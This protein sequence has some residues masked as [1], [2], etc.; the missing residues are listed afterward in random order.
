ME[1]SVSTLQ[2]AERRHEV[3]GTFAKTVLSYV[4]R[5]MG[6]EAVTAVFWRAGWDADG[7]GLAESASW[8][9]HEMTVA[10]A[11]AAAEVC[12]DADI[13]RRA[14]EE[15]M[16]IA[17]ERD[18]IDFVRAAG[19]VPA[20]LELVAN[21]STQMSQGRTHEVI[22]VGE[23]HA[24]VACTY[25]RPEDAHAFY[26]GYAAG[27]FGLIPGVFGFEGVVTEPECMRRGADTCVIRLRW[28]ASSHQAPGVATAD[29]EESRERVDS[30]VTRFEELHHMA[31]ELAG[32]E[33]VDTLLA[34]ITDR[35]RV[36][37]GA[38]RNLLAVRTADGGR[39]HVHHRGF[40]NDRETDRITR[41]LLDG[42]LDEG[43]HTLVEAVSADGHVYG[44]LV[45]MY[46]RGST[47]TDMEHRLLGA[48]ARH[49]AAALEAVAALEG[50]R[51]D[52][53]VAQGLLGLAD[54]LA[55]ADSRTDVAERLAAAI[56]TVVERTHAQVWLWDPNAGCLRL[57]E[58]YPLGEDRRSR[59]LAASEVPEVARLVA[60]PAPAL[61]ERDAFPE[62][63]AD[64]VPADGPSRWALVPIQARGR[65]FGAVTVGAPSFAELTR[66]SAQGGELLARLRGMADQAATALDNAEL[67]EHIRAQALVDALT[68]LPN[69][70]LLEDRTR[71]AL[72]QA[73]RAGHGVTLVFIDLDDFKKVNDTLGHHAGDEVITAAA[74]RLHGCLRAS[75]TLA[76]IGG[77]EFVALLP[78]NGR[79]ELAR[80]VVDKIHEA[81]V[82]PFAVAGQEVLLSCSVGVACSPEHGTDHESLLRTADAAM[83]AAKR[84]GGAASAIAGDVPRERSS[85]R[86]DLESRLRSAIEHG[87]L[88]VLYQPQVD[89]AT[90]Q[91][92]GVEALVRWDHPT[93]GRLAPGAF[94]P[95]AERSGLIGPLDRL[96]L[97]R[98]VEQAR[99]WREQHTPTR[100]AVNL[101]PRSLR[102]RS[103][104]EHLGALLSQHGLPA[105]VIELEIS[106]RALLDDPEL[107]RVLAELHTLGVRLAIDD[108]GTGSTALARLGQLPLH[109][110]KIDRSLVS[111]IGHQ[112][113]VAP[114]I[115]GL[116]TMAA[117]L[118]VEVV[119]EGVETD[120]Q[121]AYLRG[122]GL[123]GH[124]QGFLFSP[125]VEA[126]QIP[127]LSA[128]PAQPA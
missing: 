59:S 43:G 68:G 1:P 62:E 18:T 56:P 84:T 45:A 3:K 4:R 120:A 108:L 91:Q 74:D 39:L 125:P 104:P 93:M 126:A 54:A 98:A 124:A 37:V 27:Y 88:T 114:V 29:I 80:T 121:L 26:C 107:H 81:F 67:I 23:G 52:R 22:D 51:R 123:C 44:W 76:R 33:D 47:P 14:G 127:A 116:L 30:I 19:S 11:E 77:D 106:E 112:E 25:V 105:D 8:T 57:E 65:F 31:T 119:A 101:S 55:Q 117:G 103:L 41:R 115:T 66:D 78:D 79:P 36:A 15:L 63:I 48:Y 28:S 70:T 32:A 9:T 17:H 111:A 16:R 49:A 7:A 118:Q 2:G 60:E 92:R 94:L 95:L 96:V 42:E 10:I 35:A 69:R 122:S 24:S 75:D 83:Y 71:T 20:A 102:D 6:E 89:L 100:V 110:I 90:L 86:L 38:P 128:T 97:T 99:H 50:A 13:G 40:E 34:R 61:L 21:V 46:P 87:E 53:D 64:L 109:T 85:V 58:Q 82:A 72:R 12:G 73:A 5:A 113:R